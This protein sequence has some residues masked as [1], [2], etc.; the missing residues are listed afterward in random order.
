MDGLDFNYANNG[1]WICPRCGR[2]NAPF[3]MF[4]TCAPAQ[5]VTTDKTIVT[6]PGSIGTIGGWFIDDCVEEIKR[7]PLQVLPK[8]ESK[9]VVEAK[10]Q[11]SYEEVIAPIRQQI[12]EMKR[13]T[14]EED[15]RIEE[16]R[17]AYNLAIDDVLELLDGE[18][19]KTIVIEI[20][21]PCNHRCDVCEKKCKEKKENE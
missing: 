8:E 14:P 9:I 5:T 15:E 10:P 6:T 19:D 3:A 12:I 7:T 13:T 4:C 11:L 1:G 16:R 21:A 18:K 2:V 17:N 20:S